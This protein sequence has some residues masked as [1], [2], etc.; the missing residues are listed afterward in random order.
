M[1][2]VFKS[3]IAV[4]STGTGAINTAVPVSVS[5]GTN[6]PT[7]IWVTMIG[8]TN[9]TD[10]AGAANLK[11]SRGFGV[12][13]TKRGYI[14]SQ[15]ATGVPTTI[16]DA[17]VGVDCILRAISTS[18]TSTGKLDIASFGVDVINFIIDEVFD[19]DYT[20]LVEAIYSNEISAADVYQFNKGTGA[21]QSVT[22]PG[23]IPKYVEHMGDFETGSIPHLHANVRY[24]SFGRST[25]S[26]VA[27]Q[28]IALALEDNLASSATY[29]YANG[30]D[31]IAAFF[32][33]DLWLRGRVSGAVAGGYSIQWVENDGASR[34][35]VALAL[36]GNFSVKLVEF[37]TQTNTST[38]MEPSLGSTASLGQFWSANRADHVADAVAAATSTAQLSI[39]AARNPSSDADAQC[40][41][42]IDPH[43]VPD[44]TTAT[45]IRFSD[46]YARLDTAGA[47]VGAATIASDP[48]NAMGLL[49]S[50]AD[51]SQAQVFGAL[52]GVG[53]VAIRDMIDGNWAI[54]YL[55]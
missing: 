11:F 34:P 50:D 12:G 25:V 7:A 30:D 38:P 8:R 47:I 36:A 48:A 41:A 16:T 49:M 19:A 15:S 52:W 6:T 17:A 44:T 31:C 39:G 45:A 54:P 4:G 32:A 29:V 10:A 33:G 3:A 14:A 43:N 23:F 51:P 18:G 40:V 28:V 22:T 35:I 21:T 42:F 24:F 9:L 1:A 20:F 26:P 2:G 5:L 27:N 37:L 53:T 46:W 13:P 55:R